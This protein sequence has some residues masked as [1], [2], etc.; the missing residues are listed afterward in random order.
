MHRHHQKLTSLS[1][2]LHLHALFCW[3]LI[4]LPLFLVAQPVV[5]HKP[6]GDAAI[7]RA[8]REYEENT[9]CH[10]GLSIYDVQKGT[11]L[12]RYQENNFFIPASNVKI[13]TM[14]AALQELKTYL[15]AAFTLVKGD[16]LFVWGA[17]DP[18][19]L[20]PERDTINTFVGILRQTEK[21]I[22]FSNY[23]FQT[24]RYGKGWAWDDHPNDYQA[25]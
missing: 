12:F 14:Y 7:A 21:V 6:E 16:T 18:G 13:L 2:R 20:Y 17:G 23:H 4:L 10:T 25:E 11:Y 24:T 3:V 15:D 19:T 1:T 8:L 5:S 22:V 9:T